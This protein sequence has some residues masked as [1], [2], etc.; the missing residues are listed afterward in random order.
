MQDYLAKKADYVSVAMDKIQGIPYGTVVKIPELDKAFQTTF[1][2]RVV[3]TG[4]RFKGQGYK[5]IDICVTD[6]EASLDRPSTAH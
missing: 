4:G 1:E 5:K 2:F 3:D 6:R